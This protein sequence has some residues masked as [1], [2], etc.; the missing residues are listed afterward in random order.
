MHKTAETQVSESFLG[1]ASATTMCTGNLR[2]GT[3]LFYRFLMTKDV[4]HRNSSLQYFGIILLFILG[5][6]IG[7]WLSTAYEEKAVLV[8][9]VLLGTVIGLMSITKEKQNP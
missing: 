6:A 1:N 2:S 5:A 3:E 4:R 9:C 7:F 8:C